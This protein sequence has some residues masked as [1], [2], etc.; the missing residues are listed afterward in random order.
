[1]QL[2]GA[3]CLQRTRRLGVINCEA[4]FNTRTSAR[5]NRIELPTIIALV[6]LHRGMRSPEEASLKLEYE[7]RFITNL[8]AAWER[9]PLT[10]Y[11]S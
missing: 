2:L 10:S 4:I 3:H 9:I 1:M 8:K 6:A 5:I 7:P 11:C